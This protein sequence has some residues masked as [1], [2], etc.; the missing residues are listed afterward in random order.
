[1]E[2]IYKEMLIYYLNM[3]RD[4]KKIYEYEQKLPHSADKI[5][6]YN[7]LKDLMKKTCK[8]FDIVTEVSTS[9][10]YE[11]RILFYLATKSLQHS[12]KISELM[13]FLTK[14]SRRKQREKSDK[15]TDNAL[16]EL[17]NKGLIIQDRISKSRVISLNFER[18]PELNL[19]NEIVSKSYQEKDKLHEVET[20]TVEES[21]GV[22][23]I[24]IAINARIEE[25]IEN[26]NY[27]QSL[28]EIKGFIKS[29]P[30]NVDL[31]IYKSRILCD[32][33][34][35]YDKALD[36]VEVGLG[37]N[38]KE[39]Y[40]Y[41]NKA[42]ILFNMGK[43][44]KAI[45][46]LDIAIDL[47]GTDGFLFLKKS[48]WLTEKG[49]L[50]RALIEI[51]KA[52]QN[53]PKYLMALEFKI[54]LLERLESYE[55]AILE[56]EKVIEL[57][58]NNSSHYVEK[59][60]ILCDNIK[61]YELALDAV[62]EGLKINKGN[63]L[64]FVNKG[65]ILTNM[66]RNE[67]AIEAI[68]KALAIEEN[69]MFLSKKA[70][71]FQQKG[72]LEN[73][74]KFVERT[75][76]KNFI[77]NYS[78]YIDILIDLQKYSLALDIIN[79]G[80]KI[81]PKESYLFA[82]KARMLIEKGLFQEAIDAVEK[83]L[84]LERNYVFA[85]QIKSIALRCLGL[86]EDSLDIIEK[87]ISLEPDDLYSYEIKAEILEMVEDNTNALEAINFLITK[88]KPIDYYYY[89]IK[90]RTLAR[91]GNNNE[92]LKV[93]DEAIKLNPS[94]SLI[95]K[96][97]AD[98][99]GIQKDYDSALRNIDEALKL[100]NNDYYSYKMKAYALQ[101]LERYE[102][103]LD[104]INKSIKLQSDHDSY[105]IKEEC[106][107]NLKRYEEALEAIEKAIISGEEELD[108]NAKVRI[109]AKLKR[110][111]EAVNV[112]QELIKNDSENELYYD[113]Y[114]EILMWSKEF[115]N[116]I[117]KYEKAIELL[118]S[119]TDIDPDENFSYET[120]IKMGKCY[121]E[122]KNREA[123]LKHLQ[124]GKKI[125]EE[126]N[127]QFWVKKATIYLKKLEEHTQ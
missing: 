75:I 6:F 126:K 54:D 56:Y 113:T 59:S 91:L 46:I 79:R 80:I 40:L 85:L 102:E 35:Q 123:A 98:I 61:D 121:Y 120:F 52:I 50:F 53:N 22:K 34:K 24:K 29:Y 67:D 1:M 114:G 12:T 7:D 57:D 30:D 43:L 101:S 5:N 37:I 25:L 73:A 33:L 64:L 116:A 122:I 66:G 2:I 55:A 76:E 9:R 95:Y 89:I 93:L 4:L 87:A 69:D 16:E 78:L 90:G 44:D 112:I 110:K 109:L 94:D 68:D 105:I 82:I 96:I 103:A 38:D 63:P 19:F 84:D 92:A 77:E 39:V 32:Y 83:S 26:E 108:L 106:L 28:I 18:F 48:Y 13:R 8:F 21:E 51:E 17:E 70:Y 49:S 14:G 72:D 45:E 127:N 107:F 36:T 100:D 11:G 118:E 23:G 74:L 115:E 27:E 86:M 60:R 20:G 88:S 65:M 31:Y 41:S 10:K 119:K 42:T 62:E 97:K 58:S 15:A 47:D 71:L 99:Y 81:N 117:E 111:E 124:W 3:K 125:A 104:P